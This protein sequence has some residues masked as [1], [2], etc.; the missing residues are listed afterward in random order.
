MSL[1]SAG[2]LKAALLKIKT[3]RMDYSFFPTVYTYI[4]KLWQPCSLKQQPIQS[5][6]MVLFILASQAARCFL[7]TFACRME[8]IIFLLQRNT[9]LIMLDLVV[10]VREISANST[11]GYYCY[12]IKL[13]LIGKESK[14]RNI[15][16]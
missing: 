8:Y 15:T 6:F 9:L 3:K 1:Q 5:L 2:N 7:T 16:K 4:L 14:K 11:Q 12:I 13:F 10:V